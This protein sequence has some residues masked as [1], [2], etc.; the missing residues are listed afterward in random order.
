[1]RFLILIG[2]IY[3]IYQVIKSWLDKNVQ[4]KRTPFDGNAGEIDDVMVKDP[5]CGVYFPRRNGIHAKVDNDDLVFCSTE[6]RDKFLSS[7]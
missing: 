3:L 6:C 5:F 4:L 1:M 7:K 2:T